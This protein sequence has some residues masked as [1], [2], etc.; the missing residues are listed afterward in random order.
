[1]ADLLVELGDEFLLVLAGRARCLKQLRQMLPDRA[2]PLRDLDRMHL[3]LP[4]NLAHCFDPQQGFES[5]LRLEGSCIPLP[6]GFVHSPA[7]S[8]A[9]Q[10]QKSLT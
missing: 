6:F 7:F 5:D 1:L 4:G 3:I 10:N 2:L 9:R 8:H